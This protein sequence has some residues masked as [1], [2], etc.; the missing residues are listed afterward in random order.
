MTLGVSKRMISLSIHLKLL[1]STLLIFRNL[2]IEVA[3]NIILKNCTL[4]IS[5]FKSRYCEILFNSIFLRRSG[6]CLRF[7]YFSSIVITSCCTLYIVSKLNCNFK[8]EYTGTVCS[9]QQSSSEAYPCHCNH[10]LVC[11]NR[12]PGNWSR[13]FE[14]YPRNNCFC[15]HIL[16]SPHVDNS[17][18]TWVHTEQ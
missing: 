15:T 16:Q 11:S 10:L 3:K 14:S 2:D 9:I 1:V 6:V 8:T 4:S 5:R 17:W 12:S 18:R 13:R 7:D